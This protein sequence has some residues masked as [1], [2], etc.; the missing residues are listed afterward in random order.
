[1]ENVNEPGQ[2]VRK[3]EDNGDGN[4][5][6]LNPDLEEGVAKNEGKAEEEEAFPGK[7]NNGSVI[8]AVLIGRDKWKRN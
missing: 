6:D 4:E 2:G 3:E 1:M 7:E 8:E 5:E